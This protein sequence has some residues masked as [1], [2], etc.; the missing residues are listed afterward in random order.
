MAAN[1]QSAPQASLHYPTTLSE[2]LSWFSTD[3]D[4]RDYLKW[5]RWPDG[6]TCPGVVEETGEV[7]GG[8]GWELADGRYEC[9]AC[10]LRTSV[11]AGTIFDGTR[12]ALT[13][14][15]HAA[16]LFA[17]DKGGI[18]ALALK[19]QLG[20]GSYQTA[21]TM[22]TRFR[23][24]VSDRPQERLSGTVQVDEFFF[25]GVNVGGSG[26]EKGVKVP[27]AVAVEMTDHGTGRCRL[28][29]IR[30]RSEES[31]R[32]FVE[33]N[34]EPG[35]HIVSDGAW[36][37]RL[38]ATGLYTH[39]RRVNPKRRTK[40]STDPLASAHRVIA[41]VRRWLMGTHQGAVGWEHL[42]FYLDEFSFR[43]NRRRSQH[44]G[45]L[46]LRLLEV[47]VGHSKMPYR[48]LLSAAPRTHTKMPTPPT[49][50]ARARSVERPIAQRPWR[51]L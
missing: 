20:L 9:S 2:F 6:F 27:V 50:H 45:L 8:A 39:E 31:V 1:H 14:W 12:T 43:Y 7:C 29:P 11:T 48:S 13:I 15:L 49:S 26:M 23:A 42:E 5:L 10:G 40:K 22:L 16:W 38:V 35:S 41:L 30:D 18:S 36:A 46:F 3:A 28:R 25:G 19:R 34:V 24:A 47:C 37:T 4:C 21:W 51:T 32:L 44:R 17:T 33:A